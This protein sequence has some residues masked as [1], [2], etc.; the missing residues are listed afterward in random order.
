MPVAHIVDGPVGTVDPGAEHRAVVHHIGVC[1]LVVA[2]HASVVRGVYLDGAAVGLDEL[3]GPQAHAVLVVTVARGNGVELKDNGAAVAALPDDHIVNDA[4][5][6]DV[7]VVDAGI[8]VD[9]AFQVTGVF[10]AVA[11]HQVRDRFEVKVIRV[12]DRDLVV[13]GGA[14]HQGR[15]KGRSQETDCCSHVPSNA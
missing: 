10:Y 14:T 5:M 6:V 4:V 11:E 13:R 2:V 7:D 15:H 12:H 3:H 9:V 1:V 8:G